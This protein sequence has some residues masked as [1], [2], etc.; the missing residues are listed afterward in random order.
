MQLPACVRTWV[1]VAFLRKPLPPW[2]LTSV[3]LQGYECSRA[4]MFAGL[5][6]EPGALFMPGKIS[7]IKLMSS[8]THFFFETD[9]VAWGWL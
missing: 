3:S 9:Y 5:E 7:T 2:S 6:M 4:F 8:L 1:L